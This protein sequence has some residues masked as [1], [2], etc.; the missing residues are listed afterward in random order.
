MRAFN[1]IKRLSLSHHI[2]LLI[3]SREVQKQKNFHI[4]REVSALCDT[5]TCVPIDPRLDLN[6]FF[7]VR[8]FKISRRLYYLFFGSIEKLYCSPKMIQTL[9][10]LYPEIHFDIIHVF[11]IYMMGFAACFFSPETS[12]FLQLDLD[13]I[14]SRTHYRLSELYKLNKHKKLA[15]KMHLDADYYQ[16]LEKQVL[17]KADRIFVCSVIDKKWLADKYHNTNMIIVP[18]IVDIPDIMNHPHTNEWFTFLFIGSLGYYPNYEG[19]VHFCRN[20]LPIIREQA[21]K[22]FEVHIVGTGITKKLT[23]IL[24]AIPNVN[25]IGTV[26]NVAP[27]YSAAGAMIVPVRAGG[28]TRIKVL[29]AFAHQCP[30]VSTKFG[31]EGIAGHHEEHFLSSESDEDFAQNCLRL[32]NEPLFARQLVSNAF[33]LVKTRYVFDSLKM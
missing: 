17:Q 15:E 16:K 8:L 18:N 7:R 10:S 33:D 22:S 28:G 12:P 4:G 6:L 5:I 23:T 27:Q 31:V 20:I 29:E 14:E 13:D 11:R 24:S 30:V 9:K 19:I 2:H 25:I 1:V 26:P 3:I 32:M 21:T